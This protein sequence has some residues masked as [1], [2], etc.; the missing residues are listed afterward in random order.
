[1]R[2]PLVET[3]SLFLFPRA[4][5]HLSHAKW[6]GAK[7]RVSQKY[8]SWKIEQRCVIKEFGLQ[9]AHAG[10][11]QRICIIFLY[12]RGEEPHIWHLILNSYTTRICYMLEHALASQRMLIDFFFFTNMVYHGG[13]PW[14]IHGK[15]GCSL[16]GNECSIVSNTKSKCA[17]TG[18]SQ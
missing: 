10:S 3:L 18:D 2:S 17:N 11:L 6:D 14:G 7:G 13:L 9:F 8:R 16:L 5:V 12:F 1:M 15:C 4:T